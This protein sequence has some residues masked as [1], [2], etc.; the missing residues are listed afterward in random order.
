MIWVFDQRSRSQGH[1]MQNTEGDRVAGVI[2]FAPLTSA[3][4]LVLTA[5]SNPSV[6]SVTASIADSSSALVI[7]F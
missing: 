2:E 7:S 5:A 4:H 6:R 3:H 1:K